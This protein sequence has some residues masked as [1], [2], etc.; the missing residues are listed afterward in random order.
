LEQARIPAGPVYE[1]DETIADPQV[2]ARGL[3]QPH[4]AP[5]KS[6]SLPLAAPPAKLS[7]TPAEVRHGAPALGQHTDEILG[8]LGFTA[9]E[10]AGFRAREIV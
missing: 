1:L 4:E 10:I 5:D 7:S 6:T 2:V 8:E 9:S 3:L